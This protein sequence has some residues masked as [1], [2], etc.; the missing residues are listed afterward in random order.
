[1]FMKRDLNIILAKFN[2]VEQNFVFIFSTVNGLTKP[3]FTNVTLD[4]R[5]SRLFVR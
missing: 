3:I 1:M 2:I 4:L 5:Q